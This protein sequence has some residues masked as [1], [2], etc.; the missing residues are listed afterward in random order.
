MTHDYYTVSCFDQNNLISSREEDLETFCLNNSKS[1]LLYQAMPASPHQHYVNCICFCS[2]K[3][4]IHL[5]E[6]INI[7]M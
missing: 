7:R 4:S 6:N 5:G 2:Y 3:Q 1:D